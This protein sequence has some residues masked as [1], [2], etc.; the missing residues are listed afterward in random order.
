MDG[1][2]EIDSRMRWASNKLMHLELG[3]I[4]AVQTIGE[5]TLSEVIAA[6]GEGDAANVAPRRAAAPVPS[7]PVVAPS[8]KSS[9]PSVPAGP[10]V[11]PKAATVAP[12]TSEVPAVASTPA[13]TP[14]PAPVA[15]GE[16]WQ[17]FLD[18]VHVERP[19]VSGWVELGTLL[20]V[21]DRIVKIGLPTTESAARENLLRSAT[22][23]FLE[24]ILSELLGRNVSVDVVLDPSLKPPPA[25]EVSFGFA[26]LDS[27]AP[28]PAEKAAP[29]AEAKPEEKAPASDSPA[30]PPDFY[31][32]PLIQAALTKFK[33]TLVTN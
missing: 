5:V 28:A 18:K 8:P 31:N 9:T 22:K 2:A 27:P 29:K 11:V 4:Q 16:L 24:G 1:L 6:I 13:P 14:A 20:S 32:D 25:T 23:K 7:T 3:I 21:D 15:T 26:D 17:P 12:T 33:A 19:L 10:A 30:P